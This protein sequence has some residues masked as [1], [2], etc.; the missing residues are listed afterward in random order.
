MIHILVLIKADTGEHLIDRK[1]SEIEV[2]GTLI[3]GM[4]AALIA[5]IKEV[6]LIPN[7]FA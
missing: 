7:F 3:S 1:Y 5:F 4:L 6:A 2:D